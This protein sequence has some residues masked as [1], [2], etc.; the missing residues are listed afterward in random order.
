MQLLNCFWQFGWIFPFSAGPGLHV[1]AHITGIWHVPFGSQQI[2]IVPPLPKSGFGDRALEGPAAR[3]VVCSPRN[4]HC[5][6][7]RLFTAVPWTCTS[8]Q[9]RRLAVIFIWTWKQW[10]NSAFFCSQNAPFGEKKQTS[11][12]GPHPLTLLSQAWQNVFISTKGR[13][14]TAWNWGTLGWEPEAFTD[15]ANGFVVETVH[16][17]FPD[18]SVSV[19][20]LFPLGMRQ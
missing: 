19:W 2:R 12:K 11:K 5:H 1:H 17:P 3:K 16:L 4:R 6:Q 18:V 10:R 15:L 7:L 8:L 20:S 13:D 9:S 14:G